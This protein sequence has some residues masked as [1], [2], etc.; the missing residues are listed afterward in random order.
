MEKENIYL[1]PLFITSI[2]F[3]FLLAHSHYDKPNHNDHQIECRE[4]VESESEERA[5]ENKA[6]AICASAMQ[7]TW[8]NGANFKLIPHY[9]FYFIRNLEIPPEFA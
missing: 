1:A 3:L 2:L 4:I 8:R 7:P 5:E 9:R 6:T